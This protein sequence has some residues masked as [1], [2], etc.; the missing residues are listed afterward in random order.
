MTEKD[1][2]RVVNKWFSDNYKQLRINIIHKLA[3]HNN[4]L[5]EDLL[6][7]TLDQI[8]RKDTDT[9]Y[10]ICFEDNAMEQYA[11]RTAALNLK[12]STSHFYTH[13]RKP[14]MNIREFF[15]NK[16]YHGVDRDYELDEFMEGDIFDTTTDR[17]KNIRKA[18]DE[19]K[20]DNFYYAD[21]ITKLYLSGWNHEE[22]GEHYGIPVHEVRS[23][24]TAA[25]N[26]FRLM[27]KKVMNGNTK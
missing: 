5:A 18:M 2:R 8:L 14:T 11:T 24:V 1:K 12:S 17:I 15:V 10:K 16:T 27:H 25:R 21:L 6:A 23:N 26:R 3:G 22:Y 9:L 20:K 19:L 13:Y 7:S 4:P